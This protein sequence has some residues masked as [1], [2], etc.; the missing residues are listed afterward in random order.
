MR[1]FHCTNI[2]FFES[3][4]CWNNYLKIVQF[5]LKPLY[6]ILWHPKFR[7]ARSIGLLHRIFY[8]FPVTIWKLYGSPITS[9][10][11]CI[12]IKSTS[13][14]TK[15]SLSLTFFL[16]RKKQQLKP[17][18]KQQASTLT[19]FGATRGRKGQWHG[20]ISR[21][22]KTAERWLSPCRRTSA[23]RCF[24]C[25]QRHPNEDDN[26]KSNGTRS[27]PAK[28]NSIHFLFQWKIAQSSSG[29]LETKTKTH[30]QNQQQYQRKW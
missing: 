14:A 15:A 21:R 22:P 13:C 7:E 19:A 23:F 2:F 8:N 10:N 20:P 25:K 16:D 18:D 1:T 17:K 12:R 6:K 3:Q 26:V 27:P 4:W 9:T 30:T 5:Q 11:N 28:T 24:Q 29:V